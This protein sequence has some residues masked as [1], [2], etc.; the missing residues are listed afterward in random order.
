[1]RVLE[2]R[3]DWTVSELEQHTVVAAQVEHRSGPLRLAG[4]EHGLPPEGHPEVDGPTCRD[5]VVERAAEGPRRAV[6]DREL[7]GDDGR[8]ALFDQRD[9]RAAVR[10]VST[11]RASLARVE[12]SEADRRVGQHDAE[13]A[14]SH[15]VLETVRPDEGQVSFAVRV[16]AAV[17]DEVED[18]E[19]LREDLGMEGFERR[20]RQSDDLDPARVDEGC[21]LFLDLHPFLLGIELGQVLGAGDDDE[22]AERAVDLERRDGLGQVEQPDRR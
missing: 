15:L 12:D 3:V 10:V 17:A 6:G 20:H 5:G 8:D 16:D 7:H 18:V 9:R 19:L 14:A 4:G 21:E 13:V 2:D 11:H 1:M 22:H